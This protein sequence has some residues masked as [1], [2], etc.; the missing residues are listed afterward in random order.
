MRTFGLAA[1]LLAALAAIGAF[2]LHLTGVVSRIEA[3]LD[4]ARPWLYAV[5]LLGT[6]IVWLRW[7]QIVQCLAQRR[8]IGASAVDALLRARHRLM[9][10]VLL[11]QLTVGMGLPFSL[12]GA[13]G[14][15]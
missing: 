4:T 15:R 8:R 5:Q 12:F 1:L 13:P 14:G 2:G 11:T 6:A 10:L 9:A 7:P 3:L